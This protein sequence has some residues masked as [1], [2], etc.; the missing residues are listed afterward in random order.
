[1]TGVLR[2]NFAIYL[3]VLGRPDEAAVRALAASTGLA[4]LDAKMILTSRIPRRVAAAVTSEEAED[5]VRSLRGAGFDAFAV[6]LETLRARPN[7]ARSARLTSDGI[8]FEPGRA[9]S[10][11]DALR[12]IVH[13]KILSNK[14]S[15][16]EV[17]KEKHGIQVAVGSGSLQSSDAEQ[18]VIFYG[19]TPDQ[20][21]EIRPRSFNFRFL[22]SEAGHS[23]AMALNSLL[24]RLKTLFPEVRMDDALLHVAPP[25]EEVGYSETHDQGALGNL[26]LTQRSQSNESGVLRA[27]LLIAH[28]LLRR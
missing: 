17:S 24:E 6:S 9:F 2:P 23:K 18:I 27:S 25:T 3:P 1:M 21:V 12:L 15:K 7:Q 4:P 5:K 11:D 14:S 28:S 20:A 10:K 16:A 13:G 22:G 8:D 26:Q 19:I